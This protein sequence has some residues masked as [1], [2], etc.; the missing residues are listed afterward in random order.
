MSELQESGIHG[1]DED[2]EV[3]SNLIL[4]EESTR[5]TLEYLLQGVVFFEIIDPMSRKA[6]NSLPQFM[7][8]TLSV[9]NLN[10]LAKYIFPVALAI[11]KAQPE[12]NETKLVL[13][14]IEELRENNKLPEGQNEATEEVEER[15]LTEEDIADLNAIKMRLAN[16]EEEYGKPI[17][18]QFYNMT[19]NDLL[20]R[21]AHRSKG[22]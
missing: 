16:L 2:E 18:F 6:L 3:L 15:E 9:D 11:K 22:T 19:S 21:I 8:F 14:W 1:S 17:I 12:D 5:S 7:I 13:H 4:E 10:Y 20:F